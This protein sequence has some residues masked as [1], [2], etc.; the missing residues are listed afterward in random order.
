MKIGF[1]DIEPWEKEILKKAFSQDELVFSKEHLT[2]KNAAKFPQ[3][4]V[5]GVFIHSII[6]QDVLNQLPQLKLIATRSTG[7]DNVDLAECQKRKIPLCNVP[8]Y[9]ENTVAEY[10]FALILALSRKIIMANNRTHLG[11]FRLQGLRGFDLQGKTLGIVGCG[12]IGQHVAK[13][14]RCFEMNVFVFD[15]YKNIPLAKKL[16]FKYVPLNTLLKKSDLVTLHVPHNKHTHHL[17]NQKTLSLMKKSAYL[18][19]TSR[20]AIIDTS[21]L[22]KALTKKQIAGAALD[23]LEDECEIIEEVQILKKEF[24]QKCDLSKIVDDHAL[25]KMPNV[26]ITPHNAFNSHEA[27]MRILEITIENIKTFKSGKIINQVS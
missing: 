26:I 13:I 11:S 14:A 19:N 7:Y 1:F 20:G 23:V 6:N 9:G 21:A 16:G 18:I 27:L 15:V 4:E 3:L 10:T 22:V 8:A 25:L 2:H 5:I 24:G 12:K 17:I